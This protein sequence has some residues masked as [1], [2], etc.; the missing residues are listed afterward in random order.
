MPEFITST[1]QI[2]P[3]WL[4]DVLRAGGVLTNA[5]IEAVE[6]DTSNASTGDSARVVLKYNSGV[7]DRGPAGLI[8]KICRLENESTFYRHVAPLLP[9]A[10]LVPACATDFCQDNS[11]GYLILEDLSSTHRLLAG[12]TLPTAEETLA[13][14]SALAELHATWWDQPDL[15]SNIR[16]VA[17]DIPGLLFTTATDN[18]ASFVAEANED[19]SATHRSVIETLLSSQ[20]AE[21]L[22]HKHHRCIVHGDAHMWNVLF[23]RDQQRHGAVWIDWAVW[24][25]NLAVADLSYL[26]IVTPRDWRRQHEEALLR[27]YLDTLHRRDIEYSW[28]EMWMDYRITALSQLL[29]PIFWFA[30]GRPFWRRCLRNSID[31]AE[32][33]NLVELLR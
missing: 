31:A 14:V 29:W 26:C 27:H 25:V 33:L 18:F 19:L 24:H 7:P 28:Q 23:P 1:S 20:L 11:I 21:G 9:N 6:V 3:L 4:N 30:K 5:A 10:Y 12:N 2:T 8:V 13:A 15:D 17:I 32:D 16:A 22:K